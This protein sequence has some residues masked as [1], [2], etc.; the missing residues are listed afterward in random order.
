M[1]YNRI[2]YQIDRPSSVFANDM[3][4]LASPAKQPSTPG[5]VEDT[6]KEFPL[7][8]GKD[9]SM[10]VDVS[11]RILIVIVNSLYFEPLICS[12]QPCLVD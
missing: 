9:V 11:N 1:I 8:T 4:G 3:S 2:L 6:T 10:F 12:Q 5:A 7:H